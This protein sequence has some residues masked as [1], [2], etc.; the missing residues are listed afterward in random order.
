MI[1]VA[2]LTGAPLEAVSCRLS[3]PW[4]GA[5]LADVD[6]TLDQTGIVPSGPVTLT[7]GINAWL[8]TVDPD[9]SGRFGDK[10]KLRIVGGAGGWSKD[11]EARHFHN[12]AQVLSSIVTTATGAEVGEKVLEAVPTPL[13]VDYTRTKGPA[14]RVLRGRAWYVNQAGVTVVGPR[15]PVPANP[16]AVTVISWDPL[17]QRAD[18]ASDDVVT[19]G[20]VLVDDRFGTV[21]IRDVEQFFTAS[22]SQVSAWCSTSPTSR[23]AKAFAQA[24]REAVGIENARTYMYRVVLQN[25]VDGRAELQIVDPSSGA[26]DMLPLSIWYGAPG[27]SAKLTPSTLVAVT[28]L[29]GD[30]SKPRVHAFDD[31]PPIELDLAALAAV[32]VTAPAIA[33]TGAVTMTGPV[34]ATSLA[35]AGGVRPVAAA[36]P[37]LSALQAVGAALTTISAATTPPTST[38]AVTANTAIL[39]AVNAP[40]TQ[41]LA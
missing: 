2:S 34:I 11:V 20:T 22:G 16:D 9:A 40:P 21:T 12:D 18:I 3:M 23:L 31:T 13:G 29:D 17:T 38:A 1:A 33:L 14:G 25:P 41:V 15:V 36:G 5:W 39:A 8:G 24:A 19:P 10:A 32:K 26:P 37:L 6:V 28:F 4:T 27:I 7:I 30:P 35:V